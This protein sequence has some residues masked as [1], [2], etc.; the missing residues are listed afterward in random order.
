MSENLQSNDKLGSAPVKKLL[1]RMSVQTSFSVLVYS[2]YGIVDAFFIAKWGGASAVGGISI[3]FPL[4]IFLYAVSITAGSGASSIVSRAIGRKDFETAKTAA[5][6]A[7]MM[8]W[9]T[10]VIITVFGIIF[11]DGLLG[12]L[13]VTD[14]IQPFAQ[15]Y[16]K[17]IL[18]GAITSTGFS[19]VIRA[20]GNTSFAMYQW[21]IPTLLNLALDPVF[22]FV[23]KMGVRG[24]AISTVI[25]QAVSASMCVYYFFFSKK[26]SIRLSAK[27]LK[28]Q[29]S[30]IKDIISIGCPAFFQ[31]AGSSLSLVFINN[32][33]KK[34][35]GG[36]AISSFGI[37]TKITTFMVIPQQ[38][39]VYAAKPLIGY[40]FGAGKFKRLRETIFSSGRM[41]LIFGLII[42]ALLQLFPVQLMRIFSS[43]PDIIAA[44]SRMLRIISLSFPFSGVFNICIEYFQSVGKAKSAAFY[45]VFNTLIVMIP[46][47]LIFSALF[48]QTGIFVSIP[49][50]AMLSLLVIGFSMKKVLKEFSLNIS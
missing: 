39:I 35:G 22:I 27:H 41:N 25:S 20:E 9:I 44:G 14:E 7:M 6:N 13:G 17:I 26:S 12:F 33:L 30:I 40:S 19:N 50:S 10:A 37:A 43:D 8:F 42:L 11:M 46:L 15:S 47:L 38:G 23:F 1:Y 5:A 24:A 36:N 3:I 16:L 31:Q 4:N 2:L 18:I 48:G 49:V 45:S 29:S 28:L 21:I 32:F 34:Y